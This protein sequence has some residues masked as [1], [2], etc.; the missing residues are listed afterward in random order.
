MRVYAQVMKNQKNQ[1]KTSGVLDKSEMDD[2]LKACSGRNGFFLLNLIGDTRMN[3]IELKK[4]LENMDEEELKSLFVART[5][6]IEDVDACADVLAEDYDIDSLTLDDK[7]EILNDALEQAGDEDYERI[8][9]VM[10]DMI[11]YK[12]DEYEDG[13]EDGDD[14]E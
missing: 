9:E 7:R 4:M 5:W 14:E 13:D 8:T 11:A 2:I 3:G 10:Q 12:C 1:E 6:D